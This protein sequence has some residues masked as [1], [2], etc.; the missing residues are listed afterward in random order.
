MGELLASVWGILAG[1][2]YPQK[3][4]DA[5]LSGPNFFYAAMDG[6]RSM[7]D[8]SWGRVLIDPSALEEPVADFIAKCNRFMT[9]WCTKAMGGEGSS[10]SST[11]L[12]EYNLLEEC[13]VN[14]N[15]EEMKGLTLECIRLF[16]NRLNEVIRDPVLGPAPSTTLGEISGQEPSDHSWHAQQRHFRSV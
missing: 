4:G 3:R 9:A 10:Q 7:A 2:V 12:G 8:G 13:M 5:T 11:L 16:W 14:T 6:L 15:I 1:C